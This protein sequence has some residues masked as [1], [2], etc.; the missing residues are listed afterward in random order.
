VRH[1]AA[2][3]SGV[4]ERR[5]ARRTL[6]IDVDPLRIVD[7]IREL[8]DHMLRDGVPVA[9]RHFMAHPREE[10]AESQLLHE[11]ELGNYRG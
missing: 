4:T 1:R 8:V 11:I 6:R 5:L 10:F 9:D 7:R 2:T 3:A